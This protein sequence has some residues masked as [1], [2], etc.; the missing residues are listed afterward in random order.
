MPLFPFDQL[1]SFAF[2]VSLGVFVQSA[3]GFAGGLVIIPM[4]LWF[5]HGLPEAQAALLTATVPQNLLGVYRFREHINL[6][7]M[8]WPVILR[9]ATLP[10]G[11]FVLGEIENFP[12]VVVRQIVSGVVLGCVLLITLLKPKSREQVPFGWTLLAF[13]TS[14]F[15][16]GLSGTGG[17]MMVL[18]VQSHDWRT[19]RS[20]SFL[21]VMY[22][23][24]IPIS[25]GLLYYNCLLYTSPSP[26]DLSTSR[27]PSSA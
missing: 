20:R 10:V 1:A 3:T 12:Q 6:P 9:C 14:G 15:F 24:S 27:M 26:R 13:L 19:E 22:L 7:A 4:M 16:A 11:V 17:P 23:L 5:G 25:L 18:W 8:R 21:F 2:V